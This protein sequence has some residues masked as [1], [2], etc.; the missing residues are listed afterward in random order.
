MGEQPQPKVQCRLCN[1][2]GVEGTV[3]C[4][5]HLDGYKFACTLLQPLSARKLLKTIEQQ[6]GSDNGK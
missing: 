3:L 4:R 1:C 5:E 2:E 6:K